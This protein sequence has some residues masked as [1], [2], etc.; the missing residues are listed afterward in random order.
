MLNVIH[1]LKE[2]I[3]AIRK[4]SIL[5]QEKLIIEFPTLLDQKFQSTVKENNLSLQNSLP[6]IGVSLLNK[7]DQTFLFSEKAIYRILC[8]YDTLFTIV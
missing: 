7:F 4:A 1:H 8:E 6:L 3:K 2:P 5:C